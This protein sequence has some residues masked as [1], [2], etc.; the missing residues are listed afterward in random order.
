VNTTDTPPESSELSLV[1]R[2]LGDPTRRRLLD[3]LRIGPHN[4]TALCDEVD[5]MTR[6]GVLNHLKVL[7]GA[8]LIRVEAS[9]RERINH[10]NAT[11]LQQIYERWLHPF[12]RLWA[13]RLFGLAHAAESDHEREPDMAP[14]PPNPA[15]RVIDIVQEQSSS[16]P[17]ARVWDTLVNRTGTW[18][19]QPYLA[20]ESLGVTLTLEPGGTLW[21]ARED[22]GYAVGVVRGYTTDKELI[23]DGD[24]GIPGALHG[25]LV[26]TLTE[27]G[28]TSTTIRFEHTVLG[29][30]E[31]GAAD[32]HELGWGDLLRRLCAAAA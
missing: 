3:V 12:E 10:L 11:P 23:L 22:G 26:V 7:E 17:A 28:P 31:P 14:T 9:G 4:T 15:V 16:A 2:A 5:G 6:H 30:I 24:F 27:T 1:W 20:P 18:W 29:A 19:T 25:R 13:G 8:G 21:D 32:G